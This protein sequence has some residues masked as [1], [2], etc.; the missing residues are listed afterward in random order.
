MILSRRLIGVLIII[1]LLIGGCLWKK[2][3]WD[4]KGEPAAELYKRGLSSYKR[5]QYSRAIEGKL[6]RGGSLLYMGGA[7]SRRF[8]LP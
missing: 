2:K 5:K 7:E 3:G 1:S 8:L 6:S 4:G